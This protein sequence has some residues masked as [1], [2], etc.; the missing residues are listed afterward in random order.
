MTMRS[1]LITC[2]ALVGLAVAVLAWCWYAFQTET[3]RPAPV[4]DALPSA[5]AT[6]AAQRP[7]RQIVHET[8]RVDH[9]LLPSLESEL[10]MDSYS[11]GVDRIPVEIDLEEEA[12]AVQFCNVWL[13]D[14]PWE[15]VDEAPS[16]PFLGVDGTGPVNSREPRWSD[17]QC[18]PWEAF[19]YGEYIGPYRTPHV[20]D[21]RLRVGDVVDF[22]YLINRTH[23][24]QT[25]R[26][27]PGDII[28]IFSANDP[29]LNQANVTILSDGTISLPLVGQVVAAGKTL[30][31]LSGDLNTRYGD[32]LRQPSFVVQVVQGDTPLRDLGDAVDSR[33]GQGGRS[34]QVTVAPDGTVRLP[35]L[36]AVAAV[37]M[38]LD[39]TA[40]EVNTRYASNY[41]GLTVTPILISRAPRS[42]YV[43]GQVG[44]PGRYELSGPTTAMQ[45]L[46]MAEG[47]RT[48][49]NLRQ[50][51]VFR[52]DDQW[53]LMA[54][55]IDLQGALIGRAPHPADEIW[56]RDSDIILVPKSPV[57]RFS[58]A[59]DLY[60][61]R[62]LYALFP[63]QGVVFN[64]DGLRTF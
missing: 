5:P 52:R 30:E 36:G 25:Y 63:Q 40:R 12:T 61:T 16:R 6:R 32:Y 58:E 41:P 14:R 17:Q 26:L 20:A 24:R 53:R 4:P 7:V 49:S 15:A 35:G 60:L 37:G 39:E 57:Q 43:L 22:V 8:E 48:G 45:A 13:P 38:S 3:P 28:Q 19:A 51:I 33:F 29:T 21:Y 23:P 34:R 59:V 46:S 62:S 54:T 1:P 31:Q 9:A 47:W 2:C 42:V 55:K 44:R 10:A 56:L 18:I 27:F 11:P 50:I 64:F